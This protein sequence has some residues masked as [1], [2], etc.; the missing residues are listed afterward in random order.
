MKDDSSLVK[1]DDYANRERFHER[2]S[3]EE[4]KI[5]G[6]VMALPV[7]ETQR[8]EASKHGDVEYPYAVETRRRM[9]VRLF[10]ARVGVNWP[11]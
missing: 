10:H 11:K 8:D 7:E 3:G 6:E 9:V 4:D 5:G 1:G 2:E